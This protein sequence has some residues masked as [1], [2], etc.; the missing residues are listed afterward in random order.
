MKHKKAISLLQ[1]WRH[2]FG[3]DERSDSNLIILLNFISLFSILAQ[4]QG[5]SR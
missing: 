3:C 5:G 4:K 1:P 2:G